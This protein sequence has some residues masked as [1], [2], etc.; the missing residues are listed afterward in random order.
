VS[1]DG[2][3]VIVDEIAKAARIADAAGDYVGGI[4]LT[5]ALEEVTGA[6]PGS[7]SAWRAEM[8]SSTWQDDVTKWRDDVVDHAQKL[9]DSAQ[10]YHS[11]EEAAQQN[12]RNSTFDIEVP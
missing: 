11:N 2:Y 1:E 3:E 4:N 7:T 8:L 10:L 12:L 5:G 9:S 6:L